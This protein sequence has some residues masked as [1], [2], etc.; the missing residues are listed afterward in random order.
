MASTS[1]FAESLAESYTDNK[2][3]KILKSE[4]YGAVTLKKSGVIVIKIHGKAYVLFNNKHDGDLQL[5]YSVSG[6]KLSYE[7]INEWNKTKRLSRAYLDSDKDPRLESDL[8]ANA[9]LTEKHVTEFFK[10]FVDSVPVFR[11]FIKKRM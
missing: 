6:A 5:S 3:I 8:L 1:V 4:G 2:L 9:G 10:V 7:D 11:D